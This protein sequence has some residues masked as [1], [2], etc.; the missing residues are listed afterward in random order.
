MWWLRMGGRDQGGAVVIIVALV[1]VA[2]FGMAALV[3]DVGSLRVERR[4]LQNGADAA[5]LAVARSCALGTCDDNLAGDLA[6]ANASDGVAAVD[7]VDRRL[8]KT[9][10][11][12]TS[13]EAADGGTLLPYSFGQLLTGAEG[14]TVFAEATAEWGPAERAPVIPLA[15]SVCEFEG[16][17]LSPT[18][19]VIKFHDKAATCTRKAGLDAPGGFGWLDFDKKCSLRISASMHVDG[20]PGNSARPDCLAPNTDVL[21][22]IYDEVMDSGSNVRYHVIG[23]AAFHL[24]GFRFPGEATSPSP[25]GPSETCIR[26]RFIRFI[27]TG[28]GPIDHGGTDF[29]ASTVVLVD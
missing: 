9:V 20:L 29:G 27:V 5:A 22:P 8:E 25:C 11:V 16:L 15:I 24:T 19:S 4:Q 6:D 17:G 7:S 26:G 2:L 10:R 14:G 1:S 18:V 28:G 21:V 3:I 13:T 23:F 12:A